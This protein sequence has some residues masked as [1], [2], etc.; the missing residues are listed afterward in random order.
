MVRMFTLLAGHFIR[1]AA[2]TAIDHVD[3]NDEDSEKEDNG[4]PL[5][6][7]GDHDHPLQS[8]L[9][10]LRQLSGVGSGGPEGGKEV[11]GKKER[12]ATPALNQDVQCK[13]G[14]ST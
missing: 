14:F 5:R 13:T 9:V 2:V 8:S 3:D 1:T 11:D 12:V 6:H 10:S 4:T 7:E